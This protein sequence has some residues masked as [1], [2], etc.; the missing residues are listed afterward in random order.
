MTI[1][2]LEPG[3][4][5]TSKTDDEGAAEAQP[6]VQ[7]VSVF[8]N[9][10]FSMTV[11]GTEMSL[12]VES[13]VLDAFKT[14]GPRGLNEDDRGRLIHQIGLSDE[15]VSDLDQTAAENDLTFAEAINFKL[16]MSG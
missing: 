15:V 8:K 2:H 10:Q 16:A 6:A 13:G 5:R 1:K 3:A 14:H 9:G 11:M 7:G 4:H 12:K